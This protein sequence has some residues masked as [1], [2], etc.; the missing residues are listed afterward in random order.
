MADLT[1]SSVLKRRP[2]VRFRVVDGEAVV[3]RQGAGEVVVLNE[4]GARILALAD[5]TSAIG[6]WMA[7]LLA[8]YETDE[9]TL[10]G[11]VL[12]FAGELVA[13]GV[14]EESAPHGA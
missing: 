9:A 6:T 1:V 10:L 14:L 2:D 11:D 13:G 7:P 8:E 5:G 4:I 3:V 12:A